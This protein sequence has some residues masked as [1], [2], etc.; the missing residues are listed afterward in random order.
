MK[1]LFFMFFFTLAAAAVVMMMLGMCESPTQATAQ[2]LS[3]EE[4]NE[5]L[6]QVEFS[7]SGTPAGEVGLFID[8]TMITRLVVGQKERLALVGNERC[9]VNL[10]VRDASGEWE[11]VTS[12]GCIDHTPYASIGF[13][14]DGMSAKTSQGSWR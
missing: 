13:T 6:S 2:N 7:L 4:E 12:L 5:L 8:E 10:K 14:V 11:H 9:S 3:I 1:A